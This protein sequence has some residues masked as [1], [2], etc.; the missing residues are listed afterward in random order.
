MENREA[1]LGVA[2]GKR[3]I[4]KT[5]ETLNTIRDYLTGYNGSIA[6]RRVLI[7]DVNNEFG[8]VKN[9]SI[10][11]MRLADVKKFSMHP[12]IEARRIMPYNPDGSRMTL[13]D[14]CRALYEI[15]ENFRG[16]LF[17]IEDINKY[18]S[19]N[20]PKDVIGA[21]CT[22]RHVDMDIIMHYQSIGKVPVTVWENA[23]WIRFHKNNQSV[24]RHAKKF[25]ER[26]KMFSITESM[27]NMEYNKGNKRFFVFCNLDEN[28]MY[29]KFNT[30]QA[31][32]AVEDYMTRQFKKVVTP[33]VNRVDLHGKSL[34]KSVGEASAAIR[35]ALLTEY[36]YVASNASKSKNGTVQPPKPTSITPMPS[37]PQG[38]LSQQSNAP[39]A[40][41]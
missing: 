3:G 9:G 27:V 32:A 2:V 8:D 31:V 14:V 7:L 6:P 18:L 25:E 26:H 24:D 37:I 10:K 33:E 28:K 34:Y 16:G 12:T 20:F 21:I 30:Q 17:L 39:R 22:N 1:Q 41:S 15:L 19:H 13:A 35:R 23:N 38:Q 4:G 29:G 11:A 5:F 40:V 36:F